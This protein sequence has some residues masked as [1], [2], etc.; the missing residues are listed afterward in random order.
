[1]NE[2][3]TIIDIPA[4][5][6]DKIEVSQESLNKNDHENEMIRKKNNWFGFKK[7]TN[8]KQKQ[9]NEI[10]KMNTQEIVKKYIDIYVYVYV[11]YFFLG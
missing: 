1:M 3:S 2:V 6:N 5:L 7:I 10:I 8:K 9:S 11:F 4:P